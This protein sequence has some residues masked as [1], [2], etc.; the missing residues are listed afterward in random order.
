[1]LIPGNSLITATPE[2]G[3]QLAMTI[4][5]LVIKTTQPDD[6]VRSRLRDVYANDAMALLQVGQT[7]AIEFATIAAANN[8]WR[9]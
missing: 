8:Y 4:S 7:V 5:R 9:K 1:M 6:A 2:E 3:R